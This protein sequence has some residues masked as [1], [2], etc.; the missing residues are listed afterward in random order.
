MS[1]TS[2]DELRKLRARFNLTT[3]EIASMACS[4][5][6]LVEAWFATPGAPHARSLRPNALRLIRLELGL[7]KPAFRHLRKR[8]EKLRAQIRGQ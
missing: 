1:Q 2:N 8:A 4:S 5:T 6:S 7:D 3:A